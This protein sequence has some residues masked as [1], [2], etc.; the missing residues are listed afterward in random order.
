MS[1]TDSSE[2][3]SN[4]VERFNRFIESLTVGLKAAL[5]SLE[6]PP[7]HGLP[8]KLLRQFEK[9][10]LQDLH[11]RKKT[12]L[13]VLADACDSD[14]D[15]AKPVYLF[16]KSF[17]NENSTPA[18][19]AAPQAASA[20]QQDAAAESTADSPQDSVA[21]EA[22]KADTVNV[23]AV[24]NFVLRL[25]CLLERSLEAIVGLVARELKTA[26]STDLLNTVQC[27]LAESVVN[28]LEPP[29]LSYLFHPMDFS[30]LGSKQTNREAVT[31]GMLQSKF[32]QELVTQR[33]A[34]LGLLATCPPMLD[35]ERWTL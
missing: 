21:T 27:F 31:C 9:N 34:V 6:G 33:S 29:R 22:N 32:A 13:T 8:W 2:K 26:E 11:W 3:L 25:T 20:I 1:D 30:F 24:R 16:P 19:G 7:L 4:A 28:S 18:N 12:L 10:L 15:V 5:G 17:V 23:Q 35:P 14:N